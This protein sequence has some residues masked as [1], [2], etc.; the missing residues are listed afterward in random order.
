[1]LASCAPLFAQNVERA[2]GLQPIPPLQ[3]RVTDLTGTLSDSQRATLEQKLAAFESRKGSQVAV[4]IVPTTEP[5]DIA[6]YSIRVVEQWKLGRREVN[7]KRVDDGALLLVA[8]ND[9]RLRIEVGY[10]LEGVLTDATSNRII[11]ESV[12]PLFRQGDFY[13]GINAGVDQML[14]VI[15][16]EQLPEPDHRW[17]GGTQPIAGALPFL[18]FAVIIG[19]TVLRRLFGRGG[20]S[21]ATA[22]V[23]GAL[24]WVLTHVL[25]LAIFAGA[26]ALVFSLFTGLFANNWTSGGRRYRGGGWGGGWGGGGW[27]GGGF[28]GGGGGGGGGFSGGGGG[29]GGGG[30]SGSW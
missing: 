19:A 13:G 27:G 5:E 23:T 10:G 21:I 8:K 7:G 17:K 1:M 6:Q 24:A 20:G 25:P 2:P 12:S 4:L 3:A 14:R 29:F 16:G 18:F 22:G 11:R 28:G 15:D 9:R 30:A 26:I